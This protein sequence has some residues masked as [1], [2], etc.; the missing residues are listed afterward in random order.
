MTLNGSCLV[1]LLKHGAFSVRHP[2]SLPMRYI[3]RGMISL[4]LT[5]NPF[6]ADYWG[7]GGKTHHRLQKNSDLLLQKQM[8]LLLRKQML[9][10]Q[11]LVLMGNINSDRT[12]QTP[13]IFSILTT[14][15][16]QQVPELWHMPR[17]MPAFLL[18]H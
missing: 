16:A 12:V 6:E 13:S 4:H 17:Q 11:M 9:Q 14:R 3:N 5:C 10:K 7:M 2:L 18:I 15:G 1:I 8:L